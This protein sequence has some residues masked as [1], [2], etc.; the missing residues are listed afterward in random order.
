[1]H[2]LA[3][4]E[5]HIVGDV[6]NCIDRTDP[7]TTQFFFHPQRSWRFN[8]NAFYHTAKIT[9]AGFRRFDCNRQRVVDGRTNRNDFRFNQRQLI[10]HGNVTRNTND[11]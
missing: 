5:Q 1:M 3:Q 8:V 7:A 11:T 2:R 6:N 4:F 9:R 10:Q